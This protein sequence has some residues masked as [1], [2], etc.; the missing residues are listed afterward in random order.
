LMPCHARWRHADDAVIDV[1]VCHAQRAKT[2]SGLGGIPTDDAVPLWREAGANWRQAVLFPPAQRFARCNA[3]HVDACSFSFDYRHDA[4]LMI[5][6]ATLPRRCCLSRHANSLRRHAASA[7]IRRHAGRLRL[8]R[9][10]APYSV[11]RGGGVPSLSFSSSFLLLFLLFLSLS[12]FND[13]CFHDDI[14]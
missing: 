1:T 6:D 2:W 13:I 11:Q 7:H 3:Y 12:F 9:R 5:T 14:I 4:S 10:S 8:L